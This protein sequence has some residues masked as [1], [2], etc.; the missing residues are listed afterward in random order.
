MK[1]LKLY[2]LRESHCTC[3]EELVSHPSHYVCLMVSYINHFS[4]FRKVF[5]TGGDYCCSGGGAENEV[6]RVRKWH[7]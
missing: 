5:E 1:K 4:E 6:C 7:R 2:R 3:P